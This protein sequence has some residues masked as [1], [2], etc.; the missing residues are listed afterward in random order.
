MKILNAINITS[1]KINFRSS[2]REYYDKNLKYK[3]YTTGKIMTCTSLFRNDLEWINFA[4]FI[5]K[6]F[7][8]KDTVQ[9]FSL[10]CSDGSEAYT[11]AIALDSIGED[12]KKYPI[13]A[14]DRDIEIINHAK[15]GR[16]NLETGDFEVLNDIIKRPKEYF[17]NEGT[18]LNIPNETCY[19]LYK[20]F[21]PINELKDIVNFE[22]NDILRT[23]RKI[24]DDGNTVLMLRN[25]MP[26]I[27]AKR[28][29]EIFYTIKKVLRKGSIL[30]IGDYDTYTKFKN[31]LD[32][33]TFCKKNFELISKNIYR[34]L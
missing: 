5:Q 24:K 2:A 27:A 15:Q 11:L 21:E 19:S 31:L 14:V 3:N 8:D 7:E 23:I 34:R 26:Y 10:G 25:V 6:N 22:Q 16:I 20:S 17:I 9:T 13:L 33:N 30:A 12:I 1:P 28:H 18:A 29:E 4:K 32:N